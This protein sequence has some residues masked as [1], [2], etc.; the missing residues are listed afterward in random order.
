MGMF[1]RGL[2]MWRT[3]PGPECVT[4]HC[5]KCKYGLPSAKPRT[6]PTVVPKQR[7]SPVVG[8]LQTLANLYERGLLSDEEFILLKKRL[9][10]E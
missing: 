3:P 1:V 5:E 2:G 6:P 10:K 9:L 7:R 8:E 4:V